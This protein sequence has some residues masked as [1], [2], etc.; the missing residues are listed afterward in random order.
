[1]TDGQLLGMK[2]AAARLAVSVRTL[3]RIV[4]DRELQVVHVRGRACI[5]EADLLAYVERNKGSYKR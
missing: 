1:M 2:D 3:R 4:A 5:A